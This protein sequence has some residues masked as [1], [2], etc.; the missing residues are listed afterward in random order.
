M[1]DTNLPGTLRTRENI[2]AL[3]ERCDRKL[4]A[5][6]DLDT[7]RQLLALP[8][9]WRAYDLAHNA[10]LQ[11]IE[12]TN[13]TE[14]GRVVMR[15]NYNGLCRDLGQDDATPLEQGLIAHVA[16]CWLRL[17]VIEQQYSNVMAESVTLPQ[18]DYW[19]HRLSAAQRRYLRACE[20]LARIRK[21]QL[22]TL[23]VNIGQQQVNVAK[24]G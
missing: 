1:A 2:K 15:A 4:P 10:A 7:L 19:E 20:T 22:P 9:M 21:M 12:K 3:L 17:Q 23:Q 16:L 5:R 8:G 6:G 18:G 14:G 13:S 24:G 11:A